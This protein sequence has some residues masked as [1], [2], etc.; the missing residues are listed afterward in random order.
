M[1]M[2]S[3]CETDPV[4]ENVFLLAIVGYVQVS[5]TF[6]LVAV[7]DTEETAAFGITVSTMRES[8]RPDLFMKTTVSPVLAVTG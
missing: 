6:G 5:N 3:G 2:I 7:R 8:P 1:S 4:Y